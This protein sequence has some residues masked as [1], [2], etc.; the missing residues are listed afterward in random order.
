MC[1]IHYAGGEVLDWEVWE[2]EPVFYEIPCNPM[3]HRW[4]AQSIFD[5]TED[6]QKIKTVMLRQ[7]NDN[8][9]A[10]NNPQRFVTGKIH[11]PEE[12]FSPNFGGAVMGDI[13]ATVTNLT[14]PFV[15][16]HAYDALNYQDQVIQRRTGVSRMTMA[17]DPE[18]LTNQTATATNKETDASYSQVELVAR[19]MAELGWAPVFKAILRTE[20][21]HQDTERTIRMNRKAVKIDPRWWNTDMDVTIDVGLGTGSRDRDAAMLQNVLGNQILITDRLTPA[22]PDKALEMLPYVRKTLVKQGE[23]VGIRN[24]ESFYPEV[25]PEDIEAGK[26]RIAEMAG[27]PPPEVQLE[28]M[29]QEGAKALKEVDAQVTQQTAQLKAEGD[30][31]KNQA[32]LEADMQTKEADRQNALIIAQQKQQHDR[33]LEEAR[34]MS[35]EKIKLA[36]MEFKTFEL[37][38]KTELERDK[39][40]NAAFIASQKPDPKP[41]GAAA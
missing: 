32:E 39:M 14:V 7:A 31:V 4:E 2:D 8:T 30:I 20:V 12:L 10:T 25:T 41:S 5:E 27:K 28:Q 18:A 29:K 21:K 17:L 37:R 11:N 23:A 22:F 40:A 35:A 33:E 15:A 38:V 19:N 1:R 3:P 36:E 9:Y 6:V 16:N 13:G 26:K 24:I 34:I